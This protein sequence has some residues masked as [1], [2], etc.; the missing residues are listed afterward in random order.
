[1]K[2]FGASLFLAGLVSAAVAQTNAPAT[3]ALSLQDCIAEALK[4][5]FDVRVERYEPVKS[6]ISL[7]AAYAGYDPTLNISGSHNYNVSPSCKSPYSTNMCQRRYLT[8]IHSIPTLAGCCRGDCIMIS[9]ATF[10]SPTVRKSA[11]H[12]TIPEAAWALL[13]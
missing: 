9:A 3:R 7:S 5:N 13:P 1:M 11:F 12:L 8:E 4:H 10:R 6:Q 2:K